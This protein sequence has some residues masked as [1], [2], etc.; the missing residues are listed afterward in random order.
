[1]L[2]THLPGA[3]RLTAHGEKLLAAIRNAGDAGCNRSD[4]AE[5][6]GKKR[7]TQ[8]EISLIEVLLRQGLIEAEKR[9]VPGVVGYEYVYR[10]KPE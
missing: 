4:I 8:W 10:A 1:M 2:M 9:T 3:S 7:L 5:A 6:L